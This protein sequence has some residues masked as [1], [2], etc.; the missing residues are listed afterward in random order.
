M[1]TLNCDQLSAGQ[2]T[3]WPTDRSKTPDVLDFYVTKGIARNYTSIA[4]SLDLSSDHTPVTIT[5]SSVIKNIDKLPSLHNNNTNWT[6]FRDIVD[7]NINLKIPLKNEIDIDDATERLTQLIQDAAWEA[8][9]ENTVGPSTN[10]YPD[11]IK[12][13]IAEKRRARRRWQLSRN[14]W[15]KRSLNRKTRELKKLLAEY[16]NNNFN[17]YLLN[18]SNT[19][20]SDYSLW[21][22]TKRINSGQSHNPPIRKTNGDWAQS[23]LEKSEVFAE[24]LAQVFTPLASQRNDEN[25]HEFLECPLPMERPIK[26]ISPEEVGYMIH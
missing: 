14:P 21:K 25:I 20:N 19:P 16:N 12:Q 9:P 3:Y 7:K 5:Y 24:H 17:Q 4:T 23:D 10:R 2:P 22:A 18:L 26:H 15:D 13:K 11:E 1:T 6:V 8:T